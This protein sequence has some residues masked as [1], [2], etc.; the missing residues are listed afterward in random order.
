MYLIHQHA[1]LG[2]FAVHREDV[3]VS[4]GGETRLHH[5]NKKFLR[6]PR[7]LKGRGSMKI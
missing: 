3:Q 5:S 7:D 6:D 1:P 4:S 2:W